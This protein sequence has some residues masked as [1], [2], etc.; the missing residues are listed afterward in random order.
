MYKFI[1]LY[2]IELLGV[3]KLLLVRLDMVRIHAYISRSISYIE[4]QRS[5]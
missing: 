5:Q 4:L 1:E 2:I 3:P